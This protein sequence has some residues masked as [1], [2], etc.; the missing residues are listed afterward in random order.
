MSEASLDTL[1]LRLL[2]QPLR[3]RLAGR[4]LVQT[5]I[6]NAGWL[7]ADKVVRLGVGVFL[8]I[9]I[10]RYLGPALF[11]LLS[12]TQAIA[13]MLSFLSTLGLPDILIRD[14]AR[15]SDRHR[16]ILASA[17]ILR[18]AGAAAVILVSLVYIIISR[19]DEPGVWLLV[20]LFASSQLAQA[21]DVIDTEYQMASRVRTVVLLRNMNFIVFSV[22]KI[23]AVLTGSSVT[24]FAVLYALELFITALLLWFRARRDGLGFTLN[25]ASRHEMSRLLVE[26]AP[27][28][29]RLAAIGV[30]LRIDQILIGWMEGDAA[31][32]LYVA[33]TRLTEPWYLIVTAAMTAFVPRLAQIHHL[34]NDLYEAQLKK[35]IRILVWASVV[36][37]VAM[38]VVAPYAVSIL[39]GASFASAAP[40]LMIHAWAAIFST[41][42][43]TVSAWFINKRLIR[44]GVYQSIASVIVNVVLCLVLIPRLGIAGAAVAAVASQ[45]VAGFAA[46]A[47]FR[48][49]RPIFHLQLR[50]ILWR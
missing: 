10:A 49:T 6:E 36:M 9:W 13:V 15:M 47:F 18:L 2:P 26:C 34:Q 32:G 28:I 35:V 7:V 46:N 40:V 44:Y 16:V 8:N 45:F 38:T 39:Y 3:S 25:D 11:G 30:Y 50:A 4:R 14:L 37:A 24:V 27:L 22:I 42:G 5:L 41:L 29:L 12:Y 31:V 48:A 17:F 43:Q 20:A 19:P 1:W 33:A 23:V 21:M